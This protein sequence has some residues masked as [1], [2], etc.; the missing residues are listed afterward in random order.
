[1]QVFNIPL[2]IFYIT[3]ITYIDVQNTIIPFGS[4]HQKITKSELRGELC[5]GKKDIDIGCCLHSIEQLNLL[6]NLQEL[7]LKGNKGIELSPLRNMNQLQQLNLEE[8]DQLNTS[9]LKYLTSL[10][11]L[12]LNNNPGVDVTPLQNLTLLEVLQLEDCGIK[13]TS[14]LATLVNLVDLNLAN[15][16]KL[17]I[18]SLQY[19]KKLTH[20]NIQDCGIH[21]I[22]VVG[23]LVDLVIL[24]IGG[25]PIVYLYALQKLN[26]LQEVG[27]SYGWSIQDY[28]VKCKFLMQL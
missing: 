16:I 23:T 10:R 3:V 5:L 4:V 27:I 13:D 15:N 26:G 2:K 24:N 18:T 19:L 20:L 11:K 21:D 22:Y 9:T 14:E 12:I 8:C 1:M 28:S 7:L 25:N 6:V 17:N